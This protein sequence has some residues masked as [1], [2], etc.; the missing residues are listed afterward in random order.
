[1]MW[2]QTF[3]KKNPKL[4]KAKLRN[5]KACEK[6]LNGMRNTHQNI[7]SLSF[8]LILFLFYFLNMINNYFL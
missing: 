2:K 7:F 6:Q 8:F 3:I 1:M 5:E 4:S